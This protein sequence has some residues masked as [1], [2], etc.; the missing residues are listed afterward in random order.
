ML[1]TDGIKQS[2]MTKKTFKYDIFAVVSELNVDTGVSNWIDIDELS[3]AF[4]DGGFK[5]IQQGNGTG[6]DGSEGAPRFCNCERSKKLI[7]ESVF[8]KGKLKSVRTNGYKKEDVVS[9]NIP[10]SIRVSFENVNICNWT[11]LPVGGNN[12]SLRKEIDHRWGN[13]QKHTHNEVGDYQVVS[14]LFNDFKRQECKKCVETGV[15][16]KHPEKEFVFGCQNY[17]DAIGCKGCPL[18]QPELYR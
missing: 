11:L 8:A 14:K 12:V 16:Y 2:Q 13:K 9:T 7:W 18:A 3:S 6:I 4:V 5:P 1:Y 10:S 17:D 15:R